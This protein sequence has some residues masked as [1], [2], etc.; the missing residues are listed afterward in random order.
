MCVATFLLCSLLLIHSGVVLVM[1]ICVTTRYDDSNFHKL[2]AL[3]SHLIFSVLFK[4]VSR[5]DPWF[6][7]LYEN[8]EYLMAASTPASGTTTKPFPSILEVCPETLRPIT[9]DFRAVLEHL[10]RNN[11]KKAI[12]ATTEQRQRWRAQQNNARALLHMMKFNLGDLAA[13]A[14]NQSE[15]AAPGVV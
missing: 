7:A 8:V 13:I 10:V 2:D 5:H 3:R 1:T 14:R 12:F 4:K 6:V 11:L 9:R 15:A